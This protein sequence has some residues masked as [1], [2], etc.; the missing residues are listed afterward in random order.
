MFPELDLYQYMSAVVVVE[1]T[2]QAQAATG[3][4][5]HLVHIVQHRA[6]TELIDKTN[7]RVAYQVAQAAET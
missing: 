4:M 1:H 6:A 5:H 2:I 7:T 3:I